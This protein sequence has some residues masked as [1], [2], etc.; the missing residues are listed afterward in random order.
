[1]L[2]REFAQKICKSYRTVSLNT[3]L[4]LSGLHP[5]D[6]R[7]QESAVLYKQKK[8][9]S[10]DYLPAGRELETRVSHLEQLYC[11][12]LQR[13]TYEPL[14]NADSKIVQK[15][16]QCAG[17]HVYTDGIKIKCNMGATLNWWEKGEVVTNLTFSLDPSC[18]VFQSELFKLHKVILLVKPRKEPKVS[19]LS[20]SKSSLEPLM[21]SKA[22]H[23]LE[24][25]ISEN[26][27]EIRVKDRV[28]QL[29]WPKAHI[30]TP[31]N[32][33]TDEFTKSAALCPDTPPDYDK[34]L[35]S[36]SR[37]VCPQV[38]DIRTNIN[39]QA[40]GKSLDDSS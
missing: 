31:E 11:F 15:I 30:S 36:D 16:G 19:V 6:L 2:Q 1:M 5:L 34:V 22:D 37:R 27:R 21:D 40:P 8:N 35:L 24:K 17:P 25:S 9:L 23:P 39:R 18:T 33:R 32:E 38:T 20:D 26:I 3:A 28:V 12:T 29:F 4:Q 13:V 7:V 14:E 10:N